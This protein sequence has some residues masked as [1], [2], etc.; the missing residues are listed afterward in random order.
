MTAIA[1]ARVLRLLPVLGLGVVLGLILSLALRDPGASAVAAPQAGQDGPAPSARSTLMDPNGTVDNRYFYAAGTEA[2]AADE[3]RVVACGTGMP[4][5][6]RG[7][8]AAC[9]LVELGN[10]D[11][12]LFDI[13]SG[14]MR[15][16]MALN[17]PAD[18]LT[19]IFLSHLHT[20]HWADLSSLWAGGW[21]GGR[22]GPL[23]V[24]GPSGSRA[25]MGTEYAIDGFMRTFNWDFVTRA[26]KVASAPGTITVHEFD[27][28]GVNAVIYERNGVTIRTIP[29]IHIAD[30]PVSFILEWNG[31]KVVYAGDTAPNTWFVDHCRDADLL[32]NECML[33]ADQL[34]KFYGQPPQRALMMQWDIHTSAQA[35]GKIASML[36]PRHAVAYHFFNEEATRYAIYD[37]IRETYD[38]PLS[39]AD[40]LMV[41]NID[42]AVVRERMVLPNDNAW[43]VGGPTPPPLPD[44]KYT[45]KESDFIR[46]G[47]LDM[48]AIEGPVF[49]AFKR[50]HG[51]A[52]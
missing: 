17:I 1:R 47:R 48:T 34:V 20:D 21:T 43:D 35:F 8:A 50:K 33:T 2:L 39:M 16:V 36:A 5:A 23:E 38:G 12:F 41:W 27:Y 4:A 42:R 32:I 13:G 45:E 18:F 7:Q 6:R 29:A 28:K 30:G 15:N 40:D 51:I 52:E 10:G 37:G 24:W 46:A 31:Y 19:R 49:D 9:F 11:K 26:T 44:G 25:D 22:T 14:S 3:I